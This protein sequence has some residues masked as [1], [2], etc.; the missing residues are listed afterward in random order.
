[1]QHVLLIC[2]FTLIFVG[3]IRALSHS[4]TTGKSYMYS[5][6]IK[7]YFLFLLSFSSGRRM[8]D[9]FWKWT[10]IQWMTSSCLVAKTVNIKWAVQYVSI[11]LDVLW[12]CKILSPFKQRPAST[13][14]GQLWPSSLLIVVSWLPNHLFVL[15]TRW[16]GFFC[17]LLQ[18]LA[19]LWQDWSKKTPF[20]LHR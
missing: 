19:S 5:A 13:G 15:G 16:R 1:M 7:L 4:S 2:I 14:M 10:G 8:M 20:I 12:V 9:L 6:D 3:F 17:G 11:L 18:H